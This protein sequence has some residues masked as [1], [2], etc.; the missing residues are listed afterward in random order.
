MVALSLAVAIVGRTVTPTAGPE[1]LSSAAGEVF[2]PPMPAGFEPSEMTLEPS[3]DPA[4]PVAT[5]MVAPPPIDD[6][7]LE[8]EPPRDPLGAARPGAAAASGE[9]GRLGRHHS[10]SS[11]RRRLGRVRSD[12]LRIA[13]AGTE[14]V[15][16]RQTCKFEGAEWPCGVQRAH[17]SP[18][19]ARGRALSCMIPPEADRQLLVAG[20]RLGKQDVGTWLVSNGWARAVADG[21]YALS[22][23]TGA[24]G[25]AGHFRAAADGDELMRHPSFSPSWEKVARRA[26]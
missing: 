19:V 3:H 26:G 17:G 6:G 4:R 12:G 21:P 24:K 10:L 5:A 7:T 25:K 2:G 23:A 18:P 16:P 14:S 9:A 11:G 8:R 22:R 1:Q 20:C 13:I 15:D